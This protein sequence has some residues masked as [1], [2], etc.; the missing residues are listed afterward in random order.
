MFRAVYKAAT[1]FTKAPSTDG[2]NVRSPNFPINRGVLQGDITSP[3]FFILALELILRL[4]DAGPKGVKL[5]DE[6]VIHTLGFADD[7]SLVDY[8]DAD[9]VSTASKRVTN[10]AK[11]SKSSDADM[12]ISI[13]KSKAM[14]VRAQDPITPTEQQEAVAVCKFSCPHHGCDKVF[15]RQQV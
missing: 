13:P 11:G 15:A 10:I 1:A 6:I 5:L 4:H 2:T 9:G 3:L 12:V 7:V 8:G 14:H